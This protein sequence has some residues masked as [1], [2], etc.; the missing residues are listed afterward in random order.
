MSLA[1]KLQKITVDPDKLLLDPNNPRL[2]TQEYDRIPLENY[3]DPGVQK[4]THD[5]ITE[6]TSSGSLY[7]IPDLVKS[8]LS[9][10]YVPEAGGYM[11]VRAIKNTEYYVVLEGNRRLTAIREIQNNADKHKKQHS[12]TLHSLDRVVVQEIIDDLPEEEIQKKISYILGTAHHGSLKQWSPFAQAREIYTTYLKVAGQDWTTFSYE[13]NFAKKTASL[14]NTDTTQVTERLTVYR[15][16]KQLADTPE[17]KAVSPDGGII[18]EY[19]SLVKEAV[20]TKRKHLQK[21][22]KRHP[23]TFLLEDAAVERMLNLCKFN[24][25]KRRDNSPINEPSQWRFLNKILEDD[26]DAEREKNIKLVEEHNERPDEVWAERAAIIDKLTW[27]M[28]IKQVHDVLHDVTMGQDLQR[29]GAKDVIESLKAV[30]DALG[31]KEGKNA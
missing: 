13:E 31:G 3:P 16:M 8:I 18:D 30:L 11:F 20:F 17:M 2:F 10:G 9:A 28:W 23:D 4:R 22:I 27:G 14:L 5:Q 26:D 19:Y 12:T 7:N 6:V 25:K 1:P 29:E 15:A 21:Y 24:G